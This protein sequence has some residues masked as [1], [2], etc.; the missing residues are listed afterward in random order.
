MAYCLPFGEDDLGDCIDICKQFVTAVK[1]NKPTR[2]VTKAKGSS[3]SPLHEG[4]WPHVMFQRHV[5]T[6]KGK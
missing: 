1:E 4:V 6:Q 2:N 5:S 3:S